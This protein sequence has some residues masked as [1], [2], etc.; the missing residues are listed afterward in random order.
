MIIPNDICQHETL[1]RNRKTPH[2]WLELNWEDV[3]VGDEV[4]V[5]KSF[6]CFYCSE[7]KFTEELV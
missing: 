6:R 3:D 7:H 4:Y 2:L 1:R 5:V